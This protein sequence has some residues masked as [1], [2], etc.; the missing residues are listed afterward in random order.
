MVGKT[1][2]EPI[3]EGSNYSED[4]SQ[5]RFFMVIPDKFRLNKRFKFTALISTTIPFSFCNRAIFERRKV[6]A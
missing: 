1:L 6:A 4:G 3:R 5:P 2:K